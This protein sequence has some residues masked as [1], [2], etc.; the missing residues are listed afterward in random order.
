MAVFPASFGWLSVYF[1]RSC[2][3]A[4]IIR[5]AIG[6]GSANH[7]AIGR[8]RAGVGWFVHD[9]LFDRPIYRI[10][11]LLIVHAIIKSKNWENHE[12]GERKHF[13]KWCDSGS[14]WGKSFF[15]CHSLII[16]ERRKE[17]KNRLCF[18]IIPKRFNFLPL[19]SWYR[20]YF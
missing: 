11:L 20:I 2:L 10:F 15:L 13:G 4:G 16:G 17:V 3:R 7:C 5:W 19:S 1:H 12:H 18:Q 9:Y 14:P 8:R 6:A